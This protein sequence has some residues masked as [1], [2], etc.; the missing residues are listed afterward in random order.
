M[1]V[2]GSMPEIQAKQM[3]A[4]VYD[5]VKSR[6]KSLVSLSISSN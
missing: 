3:L 1:R 5:H 2:Y 6:K 4:E